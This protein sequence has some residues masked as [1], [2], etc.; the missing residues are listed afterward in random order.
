MSNNETEI[1]TDLTV[2]AIAQEDN[3]LRAVRLAKNGENFKVL[4]LKSGEAGQLDWRRFASEGGFLTELTERTNADGSTIVAAG[5]NSS[6]VVFHRIGIPAAGEEEIT[7][8]VRL[9]A[10]A[11]LPLPVEQMEMAWRAGR[12]KNGQVA[13]TV[14]AAKKEPLQKFMEQIRELRPE[15]II[16]DC[17]AIVKVWTELFLGNNESLRTAVVVSV[18]ARNAQLCMAEEGRLS[19][20]ASLDI[21]TEDFAAAN[22]PAEVT[23]TAERFAQ[24]T[25]SILELFGYAEPANI[26][27]FVLSAGRGN[28]TNT[29]SSV[30]EAGMIEAI[31]SCLAEAGFNVRAALPEIEKL[32]AK[33]EF[34]R[35]EN[36]YEYRVP[37]GLALLAFDDDAK[38]LNIFERLYKPI[39]RYKKSSWLYSTKITAAIA[40]V[41]LIVLIVVFYAGDVAGLGS[42]EKHLRGSQTG[43]DCNLLMQR[44]RLIKTV[45]AQRID[46]IDLLNDINT[47]GSKEIML[48]SLQFKKGQPVR[49]TGQAKSAEELYKFEK[50]LQDKKAIEEVKTQSTPPDSKSKEIKFAI[51]FHYK[52]FTRKKSQI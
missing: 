4:W 44:Q 9:Q 38:E 45:A 49:I 47:T 51:T 40:T 50:N 22:N 46:L 25:R 13:V 43:P 10:E 12:V 35:A 3:K 42:I 21:G 48:D 41:M 16:L 7:A 28:S 31:V 18:G 32:S 37:I 24:D 14:A 15:K 34:Q 5:F 1:T 23:A 20:A 29:E 6:G 2:I 11:R 30:Q 27:V 39:S 26:P 19:N 8:M 33:G 17:E 52:N 36:I